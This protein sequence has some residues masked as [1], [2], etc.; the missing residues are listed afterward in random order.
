MSKTLQWVVATVA[1]IIIVWIVLSIERA[2]G[3]SVLR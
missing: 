2:S 1:A 3:V